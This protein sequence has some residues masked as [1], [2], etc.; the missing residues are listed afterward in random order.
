MEPRERPILFTPQMAALVHAGRK[1]QTRR[2]MKPQPFQSE[3]DDERWL[4]SRGRCSYDSN[5]RIERVVEGGAVVSERNYRLPVETAFL[6]RCPY[7]VPGDRLYVR[8][9]TV[10]IPT[11]PTLV[12]YVADGCKKTES[13]ERVRPGIH[14]PRAWCR[15]VLEVVSVRVERV[16]SITESDAIDEGG[17][18]MPNRPGYDDECAAAKARGELRPPLGDSPR[19]RFLRLFYDINERAPKG[20]NPWVWVIEFRK[21]QK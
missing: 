18:Y 15:S 2:V 3:H 14:M 1:T 11:G 16:E 20:S 8:E 5:D 21:V 7:G 17:L 4:M 19:T 13:Y 9:S 6:D 10:V 12:G